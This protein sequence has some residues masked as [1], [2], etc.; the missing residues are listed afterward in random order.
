MGRVSTESVSE[1]GSPHEG[2]KAV[3]AA[4]AANISIALMKV[5]A[6]LLTGAASLLAEAIH[7]MAD[8]LNQ[9]LLLLGTKAS[10]RKPNALHPF[11]F[12][13]ERFLSAFLVAIIL[14]TMG[15]LF[16][17]YESFSKFQAVR[18]G[19]PDELVESR[20]WW[21]AIIVILG[22]MVAES[23]SL[24]T[25][26]HEANLVRRPGQSWVRFVK[27]TRSPELPVILLEDTAAL[28]GLLFALV[29]VG[30]TKLTGDAMWDVAGSAA[31]GFLLVAVAVI[32][33]VK[34]QGLLVGASAAP[35]EVERI[36]QAIESTP[37]VERLIHLRTIHLG[38]EDI[39]VAAKIAVPQAR[40][41]IDVAHTIDDAE[42]RV[43]AAS[44]M[45]G[46]IYLEPD[47]DR[48]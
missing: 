25:G 32:L 38:P 8:S 22:A 40:L 46:L 47:I 23:L 1:S 20:W 21:V 14:F 18:A 7:S 45:V 35:D 29:G 28:T 33:A 27:E 17:L 11:G 48:R 39:M 42:A 16:A 5:L 3:V 10:K 43:R 4:M 24:R 15:G 37:G 41:A 19:H 13:H 36:Q 30:A 44:P 34:I 26:V 2:T 9:I 12:G 6:W 31:I